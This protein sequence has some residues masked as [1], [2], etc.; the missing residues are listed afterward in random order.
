[1]SLKVFN[2]RCEHGHD[3]EGWFA[4]VQAIETQAQRGLIECPHCGSKNVQKA[5][6]APYVHRSGSG[7][8]AS[9]NKSQ[10]KSAPTPEQVQTMVM[11]QLRTMI[12]KAEDVGER[13][14]DEARKMHKGEAKER[15]IR[16]QATA[17]Q[18]EQLLDEGID[19]LPIPAMLDP[20]K[21]N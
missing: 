16:G 7:I 18:C 21:Q 20:K 15:S 10:T 2:L 14:A 17:E 12:G 5:L 9:L 3:F 6:S 4:S 11:Q 19:V 1:M 8:G 13:F